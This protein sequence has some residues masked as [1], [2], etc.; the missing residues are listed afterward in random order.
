MTL[1]I[2]HIYEE[3]IVG[4][5]TGT[6]VGMIPF[7]VGI[8]RERKAMRRIAMIDLLDNLRAEISRIEMGHRIGV[9]YQTRMREMRSSMHNA[10]AAL[11]RLK[12]ARVKALVEDY[13]RC[14]PNQ[15]FRRQLDIARALDEF[16]RTF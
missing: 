8:W 5:A 3:I 13:Q 14:D 9:N 1:N 16:C 10:I 4:V 6:I 7:L 15:E 12:A 11:P 2:P